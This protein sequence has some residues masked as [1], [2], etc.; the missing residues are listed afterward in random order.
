MSKPQQYLIPREAQVGIQAHLDRI[1]EHRLLIKC[2]SP[3]NTP[4]LPIK[5]LGTQDYHPVQD[6]RAIKEATITVHPSEPNPY[7][8]LGRIPST[9]EWFTCLDLRHAFFCL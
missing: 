7:T 4:L 8:L 3:W 9:A 2:H 5:K 6:L 1:L